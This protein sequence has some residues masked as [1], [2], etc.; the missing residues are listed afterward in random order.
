M[1]N[2]NTQV[3]APTALP[4]DVLPVTKD[5]LKDALP[6]QIRGGVSDS[7]VNNINQ[8]LQEP[9]LALNYREN[10][11][12][13]TSVIK[14]GKYKLTDYLNAVRYVSH[15][16]M[17][18]TNV[19]AYTKT[20]PDRVQS[21]QARGADAKT[22]SS[23]VAAYHKNK[24]VQSIFEQTMIPT[25]ILNADVYQKAINVQVE[26]MTT[27]TSEK[28]RSEAANSLLTHLKQPETS[29]VQ[30]DIT[31]K[32]DESTQDM[33]KTINELAEQQRKL[34]EMGGKSVKDIAHSSIIEAHKEEDL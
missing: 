33:R 32:E 11:L 15:K 8:L 16:L 3:A 27:A 29:K 13:F 2:S 23:Y 1:S 12:S 24:L 17:G 4:D 34:I 31:H 10:L 14:E 26:L 9:D 21:L 6:K 7:I 25:Y 30:L 28:V 22:V 18:A 19:S 5:E 20:F